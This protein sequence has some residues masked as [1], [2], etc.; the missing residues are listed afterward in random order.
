MERE[1]KTFQT[2]LKHEVIIHTYVTALER[3]EIQAPFFR[4][5][6][7]FNAEQIKKFG[8]KG[9]SMR[10]MEDVAIQKVVVSIDGD[11][12]EILPRILAMPTEEFDFIKKEINAVT[13]D[14]KFEEKKTE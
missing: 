5:A 10:E 13:A 12:T 6:E 9:V 11:K 1:T 7:D 4:N 2:P 3:R 8:S 14:K